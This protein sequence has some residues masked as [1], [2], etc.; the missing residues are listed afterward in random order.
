MRIRQEI[1]QEKK[2]QE[3]HIPQPQKKKKNEQWQIKTE[4]QPFNFFTLLRAREPIFYQAVPLLGSNYFSEQK[5]YR[6]GLQNIRV[7]EFL[8]IFLS[9]RKYLTNPNP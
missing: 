1:S 2:N 6:R 4:T 9:F 3:I 5:S 8:M 7:W